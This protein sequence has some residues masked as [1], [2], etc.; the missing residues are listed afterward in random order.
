MR[1]LFALGASSFSG[2]AL[3]VLDLLSGATPNLLLSWPVVVT[4]GS[5]GFCILCW[6]SVR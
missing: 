4:L 6:T 5:I 1:P 3:G 2:G